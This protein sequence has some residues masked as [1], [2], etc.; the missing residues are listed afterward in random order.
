MKQIIVLAGCLVCALTGI[1][2]GDSFAGTSW[3]LKDQGRP[4][5]WILLRD[6]GVA[7]VAL[8]FDGS[9]VS[10]ARSNRNP[11]TWKQG[12]QEVEM[13]FPDNGGT[14]KATVAG[15]TMKGTRS[16]EDYKVFLGTNIVRGGGYITAYYKKMFA[17]VKGLTDA[18]LRPVKGRYDFVAT[19][20]TMEW[21]ELAKAGSKAISGK[22]IEMGTPK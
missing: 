8:N 14:I 7:I 15:D 20:Q 22:V 4:V 16:G 5:E 12:G 6:D 11:P 21:P 2:A 17:S 3:L 10:L 13:T 1:R 9:W 18:Y 19:R